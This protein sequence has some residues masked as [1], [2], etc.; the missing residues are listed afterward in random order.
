MKNLVNRRDF[1]KLFG[2][3][4]LPALLGA[5]SDDV[6]DHRYNQEDINK[7]A[8]QRRYEA[9]ESGTGPLGKHI[10]RGYKGLSELPWFEQ[11][12]QGRLVCVDDSFPKAIDIHSHLGMSI[13]FEPDL[14][15]QAQTE[16][17]KHLLDCDLNGSECKLDLDQY[18]NSNFTEDDLEQLKSVIRSQAFWGNSFSESQTLPNFAK[19]MDDMRVE[20]ALL[21]PIKL[22]LWFGDKQTETWR[23][24]VNASSN[25]NHFLT[26]FSIH[27]RDDSRLD[28]LKKHALDTQGN[29]RPVLKLH[30]TVQRFYPDDEQMMPAYEL[31]EKLGVTIFFHGGRAGIEPTASHPYAMPRHYEAVF[32]NFPKLQIVIGHA[33][34]RDNQSMVEIASRY[35][36]VWLDIHG[37][38]LS[39]L[40]EMIRKTNGERLMFGSDW[41]FYHLG[42]SLA[43]VLIA[44]DNQPQQ[45]RDS[46]LRTN[47]ERLLNL[48]GAD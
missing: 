13:L 12:S 32:A 34:A 2:A 7:L 45:V 8:A 48:S 31:A 1:I 6:P 35:E 25:K 39:W 43:K 17:V 33:G 18:V 38:S 37:Q 19:E 23:A 3:T 42:T 9:L 47:A 27:P 28:E 40:H 44:T 15:L 41:P 10:Y 16:R 11:D 30:P 14:D 4:S 46:I 22:G 26:G 20:K 29:N 21:L 24:A 5:C 36:N